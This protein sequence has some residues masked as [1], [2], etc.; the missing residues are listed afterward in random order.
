[1]A[2]I[3]L[4]LELDV[5]GGAEDV[6]AV[7]AW[8]IRIAPRAPQE[9]LTWLLGDG[10][11][12]TWPV[13]Y[14]L[15][16]V[17][18]AAFP[19]TIVDAVGEVG[20]AGAV[21]NRNRDVSGEDLWQ[22]LHRYR[23]ACLDAVRTT[24]ADAKSV[25]AITGVEFVEVFATPEGG[26]RSG[27]KWTAGTSHLHLVPARAT[28]RSWRITSHEP[29]TVHIERA[30]PHGKALNLSAHDHRSDQLLGACTL[31][32]KSGDEFHV[33]AADIDLQGAGTLTRAKAVVKPLGD[34]LHVTLKLHAQP[35]RRWLGA[36]SGGWV[37]ARRT[38]QKRIEKSGNR[39]IAVVVASPEWDK[40]V[41]VAR[42]DISL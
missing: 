24:A 10:P 1:M 38:I 30:D 2:K 6:A 42:R 14:E 31:L 27:L 18:E 34:R 9:T 40:V 11:E 25:T 5:P 4:K 16:D 26:P 33:E 17:L 36:L 7:L 41:G 13:L 32:A 28:G 37:F 35:R 20:L 15:T 21:V 12:P 29:F 3:S 19:A 8:L 22:V 23:D 39:R